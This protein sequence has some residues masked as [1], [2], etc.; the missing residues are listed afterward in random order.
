MTHQHQIQTTDSLQEPG[1]IE[2]E[3]DLRAAIALTQDM[4]SP[5]AEGS[6]V[7]SRESTSIER[8][9]PVE[10]SIATTDLARF[11]RNVIAAQEKHDADKLA[12]RITEVSAALGGG[13]VASFEAAS[14]YR[15][16]QSWGL[17]IDPEVFSREVSRINARERVVSKNRENA[18]A[19]GLPEDASA[20]EISIEAKLRSEVNELLRKLPEQIAAAQV[21][22]KSLIN[23]FVA[24]DSNGLWKTDNI[25]LVLADRRYASE[26]MNL[27][28]RSAFQECLA[29]CGF[30]YLT[31]VS[32]PAYS[33]ATFKSPA[34]NDLIEGVRDAGAIP[35]FTFG[36]WDTLQSYMHSTD[37]RDEIKM[38]LKV[39]L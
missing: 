17:E 30:Y 9:S 15:N 31:G 1:S 23:G 39:R 18:L 24:I 25:E 10:G 5:S 29:R 38:V 19:L 22:P 36:A 26:F 28:E 14:V 32:D 4:H 37:Y 33:E 11:I 6:V 27:G 21:N 3:R 8:S 2:A 7:L 20:Y 12:T 16:L 13:E 34:I 35:Q